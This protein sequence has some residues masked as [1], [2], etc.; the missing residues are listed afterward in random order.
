MFTAVSWVFC[1]ALQ[2]DPQCGRLQLCALLLLVLSLTIFSPLRPHYRTVLFFLFPLVFF[3]SLC[4][5]IL[6]LVIFVWEK[7]H[8]RKCC[9]STE[10]WPAEQHRKFSYFFIFPHSVSSG[11]KSGGCLTVTYHRLVCVW[12]AQVVPCWANSELVHPCWFPRPVSQVWP[13]LPSRSLHHITMEACEPWHLIFC[14]PSLL[15]LILSLSPWTG[16]LDFF[17][18]SELQSWWP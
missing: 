14:S 15:L 2:S 4:S 12:E 18:L 11:E 5:H 8:S 16:P 1:T 10:I 7:S 9:V 6:S 13:P 17:Y 3:Q